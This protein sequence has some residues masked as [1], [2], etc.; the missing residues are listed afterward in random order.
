MDEFVSERITPAGKTFDATAM[1][2]GEPGLPE[3]FTWRGE[4]YA[5]I[6]CVGRWK[7]TSAEGARAGGD[8]YLRRHCF[9]LEMTDGKRW[10]V[11]FVRQ[12]PKSGTPKA[13][14]F[15]YTITETEPRPEG[16]G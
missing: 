16:G 9:E 15:L 2:S 6:R 4:T 11:Y 10:V 7:E 5:I 8:V 13:R 3:A 14:W 12:T 1:A